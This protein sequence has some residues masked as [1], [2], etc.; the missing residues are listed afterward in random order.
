MSALPATPALAGSAALRGA[1]GQF[2][3][4]VAVLTA[5]GRDG[6]AVGLTINSFTSVS[7]DPPL[8]SWSLSARSRNLPDIAAARTIAIHVLS[9]G[10]EATARRFAEPRPDRFAGLAVAIGPGGVPLL[11]GSLARFVCVPESRHAAGDHTLFIA[12]VEHWER[13]AGAPLLY[14]GSSYRRFGAEFSA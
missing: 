7:L 5:R 13:E 11:E 4:G 9:E 3:T 6:R 10:Q 14:F 8:V 2:A 12:R 1:L